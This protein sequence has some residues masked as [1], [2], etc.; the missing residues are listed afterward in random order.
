MTDTLY[1]TANP[2]YSRWKEHLNSKFYDVISVWESDWDDNL[3]TVP[4]KAVTEAAINTV[5]RYPNKRIIVHYMQPHGPF[6][7]DSAKGTIIGPGKTPPPERSLFEHWKIFIGEELTNKEDWWRAYEDNLKLALPYVDR[8]MS[9][10]EGKHI[11]T[12][13]HG[14]M[15]GSRARPIPIKYWD[16]HVGIHVDELLTVPWLEYTNGNR[17]II[18]SGSP[19]DSSELDKKEVSERLAAL[20]YMRT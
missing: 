16:H 4:P 18:E 8:L 9:Q 19:R 11:V 1:V 7:S 10:I 2:Q 14:E 13:D 12:S 20:G 17:R 15:L 3:Q 5:Q 6:I